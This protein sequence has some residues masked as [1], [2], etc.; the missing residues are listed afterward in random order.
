MNTHPNYIAV[1]DAV[2]CIKTVGSSCADVPDLLQMIDKL[3]NDTMSENA[4]MLSTVHK[5]KG[6]EAD[7][8]FIICPEIL[9]M[10]MPGQLEWERQ[11][12]MNLRYVAI[13]RPKKRLVYV[14]V[15][16]KMIDKCPV[17]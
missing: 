10:I 8:V 14:D 7:N 3:F 4:V 11:Q 9:P 5:A 13:T 17:V 12:E 6:L 2:T 15:L 1:A 16:E